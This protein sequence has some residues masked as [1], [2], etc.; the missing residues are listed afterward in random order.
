MR[1]AVLFAA[2]LTLF[3]VTVR[4]QSDFGYCMAHPLDG[5]KCI[6]PEI[7][8]N[9]TIVRPALPIPPSSADPGTQLVVPQESPIDVDAIL[10]KYFP[11]IP[12]HPPADFSVPTSPNSSAK[13]SADFPDNAPPIRVTP[14][15]TLTGSDDGIPPGAGALYMIG[16]AENRRRMLKQQAERAATDR[17]LAEAQQG[18]ADVMQKVE[19]AKA[20]LAQQ[21]AEEE[22]FGGHRK[23]VEAGKAAVAA[24]VAAGATHYGGGLILAICQN[25]I[26]KDPRL[27]SPTQQHCFP[28]G[29]TPAIGPDGNYVKRGGMLVQDMTYSLVSDVK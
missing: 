16:E 25:F 12:P 9:G 20:K 3:A 26:K 4:S 19:E 23:V 14:V 7:G 5:K 10:K 6:P 8:P 11:P 27:L 17:Q 18:L 2:F 21:D 29:V 22:E 13:S 24:L 28:T 15:P 1:H